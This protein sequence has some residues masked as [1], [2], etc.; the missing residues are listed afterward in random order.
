MEIWKQIK[1]Y[2]NLYEISTNGLVRNYKTKLILNYKPR[3]DGYIRI[4]LYKNN[5]QTNYY[6]ARLVYKTFKGIEN[7]HFE[8]NHIDK[9]KLNNN[10]NNLE[11]ISSRE[12]SCHR[13]KLNSNKSSIYNGV[14][15]MK[16]NRWKSY[17]YFNSKQITL[18]IFK[19]ELEAYNK[20]MQFEKDNSIL[21]KY[22]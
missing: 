7:N 8:I 4:G 12:N 3:A 18:G 14:S 10:L 2:E 9:N 19:T 20:R 6:L 16:N 22:L 5:K 15:R 13:S 1:N 11:L 17:I 21:N